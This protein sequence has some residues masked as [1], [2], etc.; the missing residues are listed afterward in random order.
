MQGRRDEVRRDEVRRR[1]LLRRQQR[2]G[3][4]IEGSVERRR[5]QQVYHHFQGKFIPSCQVRI[6]TYVFQ[7]LPA[8][9][10]PATKVHGF[11]NKGFWI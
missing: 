4:E 9:K 1:H 6:T 3:E 8:S 2:G 10:V 11:S 7:H 5:S